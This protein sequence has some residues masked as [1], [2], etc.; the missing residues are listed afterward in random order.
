AHPARSAERPGWDEN[1]QEGQ[2]R[3]R[4]CLPRGSGEQPQRRSGTRWGRRNPIES[5]ELPHGH[6]LGRTRL[7]QTRYVPNAAGLKRA[8]VLDACYRSAV[9]GREVLLDDVS[10]VLVQP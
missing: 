7:E 9:E 2:A 6:G 10:A 4:A 3:A 8:R 5:V 1:D